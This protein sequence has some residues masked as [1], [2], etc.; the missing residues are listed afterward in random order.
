[1][2][3]IGNGTLITLGEQCKVIDKGA[4]LLDGDKILKVGNTAEIKKQYPDADFIDADGKLIMPGFLNVHMHTYSTFSRGIALKDESPENF[5]EILERLWWRLDKALTLEDVYYS[6]LIPLIDCV[7][8]G[9]TAILDHHASPFAVEGSLEQIARAAKEVGIRVN[10]CYEVSDRDG[11][12]IALAGIK[13]NMDFIKKCQAEKSSMVGGTFGMHACFTIGDK[14][15]EKCAQVA[16][17]LGVGVHIHAAESKSDVEYNLR[18]Y[19]LRVIERLDKYE[20]LGPKTMT[21]HCVHINEKEMELLA[22]TRTNVAHNPQSNMNNAVGCA[23]VI[24]MIDM[25]IM[26]GMGTDG[27]TSDMIEGMKT[28]HILHKFNTNDPRVGWVEVPKMQLI[29]NAKI[30]QNYFPVKMGE[31]KEGNA[32][33]V[34]LVD[35]IPPTPITADNFYGHM[36][37]GMTGRMV[38]TT[39]VAGKILMKDKKLTS[40]DE[41]EIGAKAREL[42]KKLWER[43]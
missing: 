15:M 31:L 42:S 18:E 41:A 26:L 35:Y 37:F 23:D 20:L 43:F 29:N 21:G 5:V 11:E 27:M 22:K 16:K 3:L 25:D 39:I 12:D 40:I 34:I 14:T 4:V 32:A 9:T 8:N 28:A 30:M 1:M 6:A 2:L 7:K 17:D 10:T 24:K 38:D 13:E 33:D 19:G 36:V